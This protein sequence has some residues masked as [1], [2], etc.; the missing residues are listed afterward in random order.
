MTVKPESDLLKSNLFEV[1]LIKSASEVS[2]PPTSAVR[3]MSKKVFSCYT[4]LSLAALSTASG[5]MVSDAQTAV[6]ASESDFVA[7]C[8]FE[9]R[10]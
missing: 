9:S 3:K 10:K 4:K 8:T 5:R 1:R 2:A 7:I 6:A